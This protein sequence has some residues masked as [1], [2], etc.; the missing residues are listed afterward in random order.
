MVLATNIAETSLTIEGVRVVVDSGLERRPR[1][2]AASGVSR[3]ETVR[4]SAASATQRAGRSGR[5]APGTCYRLWTEATQ[6]SLLPF[7]PPEIRSADLS[8][9]AL[10]LALWGLPDADQLAWLD[11]PP[12]G[13][14]AAAREILRVLGAVDEKGRI[15]EDGRKMARL[16]VDVRLARLLL[17]GEKQGAWALACDLAALLSERDILSQRRGPKESSDS[18]ILD[19]LEALEDWRRHRHSRQVDERG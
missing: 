13:A 8:G 1:F 6:N 14:L 10:E 3:L 17:A 16:P 19:R 5:M 11:P 15:T 9:L 18:D 12:A 2:D 4:I 7:T